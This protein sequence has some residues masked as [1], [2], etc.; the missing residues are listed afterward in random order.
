MKSLLEPIE[1]AF[2]KQLEKPLKENGFAVSFNYFEN[3]VKTG[4]I[5]TKIQELGNKASKNTKSAIVLYRRTS[6]I[7]KSDIFGSSGL[8]KKLTAVNNKTGN[9]FEKEYI[10]AEWE[11][12]FNLISRGR[13]NEELIEFIFNFI[14]RKQKSL[15]FILKIKDFEIPFSYSI[16]MGDLGGAEKLDENLADN[17]YNVSFSMKI[18]GMV[19]SPFSEETSV[20]IL[21]F[22]EFEN[23]ELILFGENTKFDLDKEPHELVATVE[24]KD[25][26]IK[27]SEPLIN[28]KKDK[29]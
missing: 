11:Y 13:N 12:D 19:M 3:E 2:L 21:N 27:F 4:Y 25:N 24:T 22:T 28:S 14:I 17:I 23:F 26:N 18:S 10:L 1:V 9:G 8:P 7:N 29:T 6:T 15:N 20:G 16:E 5:D